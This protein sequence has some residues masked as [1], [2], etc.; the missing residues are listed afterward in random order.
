[1]L[2]EGSRPDNRDENAEV[3]GAEVAKRD[4]SCSLRVDLQ[5]LC[6][7]ARWHRRWVAT[8]CITADASHHRGDLDLACVALARFALRGASPVMLLAA[9]AAVRSAARVLVPRYPARSTRRRL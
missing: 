3:L 2:G 8:A 9:W 4:G 1:M 6:W 7:C 5:L